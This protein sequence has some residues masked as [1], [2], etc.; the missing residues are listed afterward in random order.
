[1][2]R[3]TRVPGHTPLTPSPLLQRKPK[4]SMAADDLARPA[5][6]QRSQGMSSTLSPNTRLNN[7]VHQGTAAT[8]GASGGTAAAITTLK[9]DLVMVQAEIDAM[10]RGSGAVE[11]QGT[12]SRFAPSGDER[13][14][15]E[16]S[17]TLMA[18]VLMKLGEL[19]RLHG[20]GTSTA[21]RQSRVGDILALFRNL[22]AN[23]R[24]GSGLVGTSPPP[25]ATA[26]A[27]TDGLRLSAIN[28]TGL[29][30]PSVHQQQPAPS[31]HRAPAGFITVEPASAPNPDIESMQPLGGVNAAASATSIPSTATCG[32]AGSAAGSSRYH[33][34]DGALV[35]S[36]RFGDADG[37]HPQGGADTALAREGISIR[38]RVQRLEKQLALFKYLEKSLH[39]V[40][41]F[42]QT[43]R[44]ITMSGALQEAGVDLKEL[45]ANARIS[46]PAHTVN[47][48]GLIKPAL[49]PGQAAAKTGKTGVS[50]KPADQQQHQ[51]PAVGSPSASAPEASPEAST[52]EG[53][54]QGGDEGGA[55]SP[56]GAGLQPA[57]AV[58]H[59]PLS[60]TGLRSLV[61][62]QNAI[63]F[64]LVAELKDAR[65]AGGGVP[66]SAGAASSPVPAGEVNELQER[67]RRLQS[68]LDARNEMLASE[69]QLHMVRHERA[70][71]VLLAERTRSAAGSPALSI[72][73]AGLGGS[74]ERPMSVLSDHAA[75]RPLSRML[76]ASYGVG[77][78][79]GSPPH[80]ASGTVRSATLRGGVTGIGLPPVGQMPPV[81]QRAS[82]P[83]LATRPSDLAGAAEQQYRRTI[84]QQNEIIRDLQQRL[85]ESS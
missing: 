1:M 56:A 16:T 60:V 68:A 70:A 30:S 18:L 79:D 25:I 43:M 40:D 77:D 84:A 4:V 85:G 35:D 9:S 19:A 24:A 58:A 31:G 46:P 65:S 74:M 66:A 53:P 72:G 52:S 64:A 82:T 34:Q 37:Y 83:K 81:Q 23:G 41:E 22:P 73:T 80:G 54:A 78:G 2:P 57:A 71:N 33:H 13:T 17:N 38:A 39:V 69:R 10:T 11:L 6:P 8:G 50:F 7:M 15:V 5:T 59:E 67:V 20:S 27:A 61:G 76:M 44:H 3:A 63:L 28:T 29:R 62:F 45:M 32:I 21:P 48:A 26:A 75:S 42:D 47:K 55:S 51:Q 36:P 49:E 14:N 12:L